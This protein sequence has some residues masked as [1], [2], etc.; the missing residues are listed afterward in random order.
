MYTLYYSPGACSLAVHMILCELG[1]PYELVN[2]SIQEGKNKSPEFLKINPRGQVPVLKDGDQVIREG[3]AII[4]HLLDKHRSPMLPKSGPERD[5][6]LE[7]LMFAN[8]TMHPAYGKAFFVK[9]NIA[10]KAAQEQAYKAVFDGIDKLWAE[11]DA[12]L[13]KTPY[14][15]GK[16]L[17]AADILLSVFANWGTLF[18]RQAKL[19]ENTQR[20]IAEVIKRP[21]CQKALKEENLEYKAAA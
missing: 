20:M 11:V 1:V 19:G 12:R 9:Y 14:L 8:A 5:T 18:P 4:I 15:C 17:S 21:A 6:A 3:A 13:A 7:W 16:D 10:D 2:V